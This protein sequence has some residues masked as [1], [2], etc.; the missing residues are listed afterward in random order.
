VK[1]SSTNIL[2]IHDNIATVA[3]KN[4]VD[5]QQI[6]NLYLYLLRVNIYNIIGIIII[7]TNILYVNCHTG[8]S[9]SI[10]GY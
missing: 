1:V 5:S 9:R 3:N 8:L 7:A 4:A 2:F 10:L 6:T